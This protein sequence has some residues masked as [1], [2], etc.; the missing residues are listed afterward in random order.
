MNI[1]RKFTS[2]W[3]AELTFISATNIHYNIIKGR[4]WQ[5]TTELISTKQ[6]QG[7]SVVW[8]HSAQSRPEQVRK[9]ARNITNLMHSLLFMFLPWKLPSIVAARSKAW[10]RLSSLENWDHGFETHSRYGCLS[11]FILCLCE[12]GGLATGWSPVQIELP[13]VQN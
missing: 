12:G 10:K 4:S 5:P 1:I 13:T 9:Y 7:M 2:L 8:W 3:Y 6:R 11:S